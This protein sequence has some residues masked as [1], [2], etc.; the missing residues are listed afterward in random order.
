[1]VDS[2]SKVIE[3]TIV[4]KEMGF[5]RLEFLKQFKCFAR[6]IEYTLTNNTISFSMK[7]DL[8][9]PLA[10]SLK[11]TSS[12]SICLLELSDRVIAS[13]RIPRISVII[14]FYNFTEFQKKQFIKKFD[15]SFQRGGG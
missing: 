8:T 10:H 5:T 12:V 15:L 14:K 1:M 2:S 9:D 7:N 6:E 3:L 13:L 11:S 4:K